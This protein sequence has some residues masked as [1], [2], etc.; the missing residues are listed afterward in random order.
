MT[1]QISPRV[2]ASRTAELDEVREKGLTAWAREQKMETLKAKLRA[3]VLA[4]KKLSEDG[5][6]RLAPGERA[7]VEQEI[8]KLIEQKL[9]EAMQETMEEAARTGKTQ[10]VFLDIMA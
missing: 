9:Q 3:Q 6:A 4:D 8:A 10:A 7:S 1:R 2:D 5:L